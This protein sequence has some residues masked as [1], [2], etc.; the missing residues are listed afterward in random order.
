MS[1]VHP[2]ADSSR[3]TMTPTYVAVLAAEAAVLVL[4]WLLGWIFPGA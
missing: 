2:H 3:S 4:L 1:P